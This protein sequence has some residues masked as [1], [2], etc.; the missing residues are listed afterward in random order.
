MAT[1]NPRYP[2]YAVGSSFFETAEEAAEAFNAKSSADRPSV[3]VMQDVGMG[4]E[5]AGVDATGNKYLNMLDFQ[6]HPMMEA[7]KSAFS[8][9]LSRTAP[10]PITLQEG[11]PQYVVGGQ[12]FED[13]R[14]AA[15]AFH[16]AAPNSVDS[17]VMINRGPGY[18]YQ[19][20]GANALGEK[21]LHQVD[22]QSDPLLVDFKEAYAQEVAKEPVVAT[23]EAAVVELPEASIA[24]AEPAP[25]A[26]ST[27]EIQ[28]PATAEIQTPAPDPKVYQEMEPANTNQAGFPEYL[29]GG[30][31]YQDATAAAQAFAEMGEGQ[32]HT[33]MLINTAPGYGF[34]AGGVNAKGERY[35]NQLDHQANPLLVEF[36][37]A[38]GRL[39]AEAQARKDVET[40]KQ[41]GYPHFLIGGEKYFD[42]KEAARA[43]DK[44]DGVPHQT[45]VQIITDQFDFF[46]IEAAGV[47]GDGKKYVNNLDFQSNP[48]LMSFKSALKDV[49][50]E[51][52][53]E[54]SSASPIAGL[55]SKLSSGLKTDSSAF[56]KF[57][58]EAKQDKHAGVSLG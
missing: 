1:K 41:N 46:G 24:S 16:Q 55:L 37:E 42:P 28:V 32:R 23:P 58:N 54:A 39:E 22:N 48:Q 47:A 21:F 6:N 2:H 49:Q 18:G 29:V 26:P 44:I 38:Y 33:S 14:L 4:F 40:A 15:K 7:F 9:I 30:K 50:A 53:H 3:F 11:Y 27:I 57:S 5:V 8:Q 19:A 51:A 36:K 25:A 43:F 45:R 10:T 20:A 35:L 52:Q 34:E 13:S 56:S 31:T 17:M 12:V